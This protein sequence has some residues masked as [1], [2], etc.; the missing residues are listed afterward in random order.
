MLKGPNIGQ[1]TDRYLT[2]FVHNLP[3][4][5]LAKEVWNFFGKYKTIKD[6]ILPRRRDRN[7]NRVGFLIVTSGPKSNAIIQDNNGQSFKGSIIQVKRTLTKVYHNR[8]PEDSHHQAP[9]LPH[10]RLASSTHNMVIDITSHKQ[11]RLV[12]EGLK[13][14]KRGT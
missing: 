7:G 10:D 4:Q 1:K 9:F 14:N 13:Q 3:Q 12:N 5:I 2:L 11:G 8:M 6:I